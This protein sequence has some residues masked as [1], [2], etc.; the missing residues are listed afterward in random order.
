[1]EQC[2]N[3]DCLAQPF[4]KSQSGRPS[5]GEERD[6]QSVGCGLDGFAPEGDVE[7]ACDTES[8]L[9]E[10]IDV[11]RFGS[12]NFSRVGDQVSQ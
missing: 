8:S 3:F 1:M 11:C 2:G 10:A 12:L 4:G 9:S 5:R 7:A 6:T